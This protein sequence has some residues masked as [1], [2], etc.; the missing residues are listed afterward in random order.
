MPPRV[1]KKQ[2]FAPLQAAQV[3]DRQSRRGS[4]YYKNQDGLTASIKAV[5]CNHRKSARFSLKKTSHLA[6]LKSLPKEE[7]VIA[8]VPMRDDGYL[9][10]RAQ[11]DQ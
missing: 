5:S 1:E 8:E 11:C 3:M 4:K 7:I 6:L 9:Q 2:D 10:T